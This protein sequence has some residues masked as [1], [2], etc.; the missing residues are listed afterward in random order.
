MAY[1][2]INKSTEHFNT[3]LYTGNNSTNAI[4]GVGFQPDLVWIKERSSTSSHRL[5]DAV[6]GVGKGLSS[7]STAVEESLAALLTSFDSNGFTVGNDNGVNENSQTYASWNW[8]A[9]N[10]AGSS[11]TDG[12]ITST[13]TAN[14]TAGFS[15]VK[16]VG[17]GG[18]TT[19]VGH[20]LGVVPQVILIKNL[21]TATNW[22]MYHHSLGNTGQMYLDT[23]NSF[24]TDADTFKNTTPSSTVWT[25]SNSSKTNQGSRNH[26]AYCFA[27][28]TGY[29]KFGSYTG[30]ASAE[31]PFVYTGFKPT[32]LLIKATHSTTA[33]SWLLLDTVRQPFNVNNRRLRPDTSSTEDTP[34][35]NN[36]DLLSNGFKIRSTDSRLNGNGHELVYLAFGQSLVGSN[37]IPCTAR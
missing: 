29:S 21:E 13:V 27:E 2:T 17:D 20:G 26:I 35:A 24:T 6:R 11:N 1:S 31:G 22:V 5:M 18:M 8:K 32:W 4:T 15:I 36:V 12:S 34:T 37:N 19:T 14:T 23:S 16:Y 30:N 25:M 33:E 28:K 10:S 7:D 3:K 9:G